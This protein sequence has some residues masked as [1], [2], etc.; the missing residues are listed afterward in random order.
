MSVRA[1]G[2]RMNRS[3][4]PILAV[5][6]GSSLHDA[7]R[8]V[9]NATLRVSARL[10]STSDGL[11]PFLEDELPRLFEVSGRQTRA[12]VCEVALALEQTGTVLKL[13]SSIRRRARS[14]RLWLVRSVLEQER[15]RR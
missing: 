8:D 11:L 4:D 1:S 12:L 5:I 15:F 10:T 14:D 9:T 3:P 6:V 2:E 7:D 13:S